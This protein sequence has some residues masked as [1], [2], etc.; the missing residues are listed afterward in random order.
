MPPGMFIPA[1][2]SFNL[3]PRVDRWV[4]QHTLEYLRRNPEELSLVGNGYTNM[5]AQ[6]F[7]MKM[8]T[9]VDYE[10]TVSSLELGI[11]AQ[12]PLDATVTAEA[13]GRLMSGSVRLASEIAW[14]VSIADSSLTGEAPLVLDL[15]FQA[16]AVELALVNEVAVRLESP[17]ISEAVVTLSP[18][19]ACLVEGETGN[20]IRCS[21]AVTTLKGKL[22][23][24]EVSIVFEDVG[25]ALK[26]EDVT[27]QA[28]SNVNLRDGETMILASNFDLTGLNGRMMLSTE[29]ATVLGFDGVGIL[30]DHDTESRKGQ[31]NF[32][33]SSSLEGSESLL[34]YLAIPTLQLEKGELTLIGSFEWDPALAGKDTV[35]FSSNI[36]IKD[37]DLEY[38]GYRFQKGELKVALT[39]W[40]RIRSTQAVEMSWR[41]LDMGVPV[42]DIQMSFRLELEPLRHIFRISGNSLSAKIFGGSVGSRDYSY[43]VIN[44]NGH[45]NLNVEG[46]ELNQILALER[47]D[48]VSTGKLRGS[49]PVQIEKGKLSVSNG[50]I[51]AEHPGGLLKYQ[52]SQSVVA[53]IDQNES[54][55]VVVDA[56]SDFH[57]HSLDVELEYSPEGELVA[58][59]SLKG[60]N[61]GYQN[62]REVNL[63]LNLEENLGALLE[64]LRLSEDVTREIDKK[65]K[66]GVLQ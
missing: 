63:N 10:V 44:A 62:G 22:D 43:D 25:L 45:M 39:G 46:L 21:T 8:N 14:R 13:L 17:L 12:I 26:D 52:P 20:D 33:L 4:V 57:Y 32:Q 38:D 6:P 50:L 23:T 41:Q 49:V 47:E 11:N 53:L 35:F 19:T 55:K 48:F 60:S 29:S 40:P 59:T 36:E 61:P 16:G 7:L 1:A 64:S 9:P 30:L 18:G 42:D 24:F 15:G 54:L 3:M 56:M 65:A 2:E 28:T 58:K 5:S 51:S 27:I 66:S 31:A 37:M 34:A